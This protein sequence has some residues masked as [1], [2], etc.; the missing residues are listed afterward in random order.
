MEKHLLLF[1]FYNNSDKAKIEKRI[2]DNFPEKEFIKRVYQG[3]GNYYQIPIG[4]GKGKMLDF[5]ISDFVSRYSLPVIQTYSALKLLQNDGYIEL[6]EEFFSLSKVMFITHQNDLYKFQV[7]NKAFDPFI[8]LILRTYTG[9]FSTYTNID[10]EL[11]AKKANCSVKIIYDFLIQLDQ[12]HIIRYIPQRKIPFII[13]TE[14]RLDEK[15]L[16]ISK[17]NYEIRKD[18]Y[19]NKIDSVIEYASTTNKCRSQ[20]LLNYFNEQ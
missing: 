14:E 15:N 3:L 18:I 20:I 10:E 11:L 12:A 17:E 19:L 13:Y 6:A 2:S 5:R 7:A 16:R 4:A 1:Y 9:L 8:K